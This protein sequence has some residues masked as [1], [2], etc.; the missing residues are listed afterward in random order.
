MLTM[1]SL[2]IFFAIFVGWLHGLLEILVLKDTKGAL[3]VEHVWLLPTRALCKARTVN[4]W[5]S[6][7]G[8][9]LKYENSHLGTEILT[10]KQQFVFDVYVNPRLR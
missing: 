6:L 9:A 10:Q 2:K 8:C 7:A 4:K 1:F 3:F 5:N